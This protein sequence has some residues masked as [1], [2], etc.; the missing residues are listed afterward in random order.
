V[1]IDKA[2]RQCHLS[3]SATKHAETLGVEL[4]NAVKEEN[5]IKSI[6]RTF[7][8]KNGLS[9]NWHTRGIKGL[10]NVAKEDEIKVFW[11][12]LD[13]TGFG[14]IHSSNVLALVERWVSD[15]KFYCLPMWKPV[16]H[17]VR[18]KDGVYNIDTGIF[19]PSNEVN[20]SI[21]CVRVYDEL[22]TEEEPTNFIELINRMGWDLD[23]FRY[24]YG[25]QLMSKVRG[26]PILYM[27]GTSYTGKSSF[28]E[29]YKD[30]FKDVITEVTNDGSFSWSNT[31][32]YEKVYSDEFDPFDPS[33]DM[34][35][36]KKVLEGINCQVKSK[37]AKAV[38]CIP[39][40]M[41]LCSNT[42]PPDPSNST[43]SVNAMRNRMDEY[44]STA[45]PFTRETADRGYQ[46]ILVSEA[47]KVLVWTTS[48]ES[49]R[50]KPTTDEPSIDKASIRFLD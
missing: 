21:V 37:H 32:G 29:P 33:L 17:M 39:K 47:A 30:I 6:V 35:Q 40:T 41:M 48:A 23:R 14:D 11:D 34:N 46:A 28:L 18:F 3:Q 19:E 10:D 22:Y 44:E 4:S 43:E 26:D 15:I 5:H 20:D 9:V 8:I 49:K 7:M 36:S 50:P 16:L 12:M 38:S 42:N 45:E 13:A 2:I 25:T 1:N 31:A 27:Y 24:S